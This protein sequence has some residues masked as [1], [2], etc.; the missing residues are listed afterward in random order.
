MIQTRTSAALLAPALVAAA[1]AACSPREEARTSSRTDVALN[2]VQATQGDALM[3]NGKHVRLANAEAPLRTPY[4]R[5]WAESI[6]GREARK[7]AADL[8]TAANEIDIQSTGKTDEYGRT[9]AKVLLD[10][11]DLGDSLVQDG[12]AVRPGA[13]PFDWCAPVSTNIENAPNIN[14]LSDLGR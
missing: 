4:A 1:L 11:L 10:G 3:I 9:I 8:A 2:D 14:A 13:E 6:A 5:C 12:Y 7:R